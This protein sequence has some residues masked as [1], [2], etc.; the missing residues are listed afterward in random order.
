MAIVAG[1]LLISKSIFDIDARAKGIN[2]K[3]HAALIVKDKADDDDD[4]LFAVAVGATMV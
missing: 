3:Q 2:V 4:V 1:P